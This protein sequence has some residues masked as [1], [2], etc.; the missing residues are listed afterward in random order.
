[1][2]TAEWIIVSILSLTLFIFLILGIMLLSKLLDLS[3]DAKHIM[4][5]LERMTK[6]GNSI[7]AKAHDTVDDISKT[8]TSAAK[9]MKKDAT[10]TTGVVKDAVVAAVAKRFGLNDEKETNSKK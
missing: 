2:D 4:K 6:K 8:A 9:T 7:V 3:R 10:K 1:M 5:Q